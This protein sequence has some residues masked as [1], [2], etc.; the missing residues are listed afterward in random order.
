MRQHSFQFLLTQPSSKA[1]LSSL[2]SGAR[3]PTVISAPA[4][5]P[6]ASRWRRQRCADREEAAGD[7]RGWR[8]QG[9]RGPAAP[10]GAQVLR[11]A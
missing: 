9:G 5:P 4:H 6:G 1:S 2:S 10:G 11:V 3:L 7:R 8:A